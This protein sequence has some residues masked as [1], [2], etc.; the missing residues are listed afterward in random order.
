VPKLQFLKIAHLC[1]L[2][3]GILA[4]T[5]FMLYAGSPSKSLSTTE[6]LMILWVW[7]P[8][9]LAYALTVLNRHHPAIQ[10]LYMAV[11]I[12]NL[13]F[14]VYAFYDSMFVHPDAQ[15]ALVF[16]FVPLYLNGALAVLGSINFA[17]L[18]FSKTV[19]QK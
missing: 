2:L 5:A 15:G 17:A 9:L 7:T 19:I 4:S 14:C 3:V 6:I 18:I 10:K 8:F 11:S 16:L 13:G 12:L 1:V